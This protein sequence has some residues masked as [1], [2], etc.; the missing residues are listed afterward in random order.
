MRDVRIT[1]DTLK[2][3][4][5]LK[6]A[7]NGKAQPISPTELAKLPEGT[8]ILVG[9]KTREMG[10]GLSGTGYVMQNGRA[11]HSINLSSSDVSRGSLRVS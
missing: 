5:E 7:G 3:Q 6:R 10:G 9:N 8:Y 1:M 2:F 11:T 4:S